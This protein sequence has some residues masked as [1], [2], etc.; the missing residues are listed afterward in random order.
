MFEETSY[1]QRLLQLSELAIADQRQQALNE[2][3]QLMFKHSEDMATELAT[4]KYVEASQMAAMRNAIIQR[5]TAMESAM[6][7]ELVPARSEQMAQQLAIDQHRPADL[8]QHRHEL[9]A[10]HVR[11]MA[12]ENS[13]AQAATAR[14]LQGGRGV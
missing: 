9:G 6:Q 5:A 4:S 12:L 14:D 7:S 8:E 1:Q 3:N 11:Q 10:A 13:A 2:M